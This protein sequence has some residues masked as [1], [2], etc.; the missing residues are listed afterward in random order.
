MS[1]EH[2]E[3]RVYNDGTGDALT[4]LWDTANANV[5]GKVLIRDREGHSEVDIAW[6]LSD[7]I[8][9]NELT[10]KEWSSLASLAEHV[11]EDELRDW[12]QAEEPEK[13]IAHHAA[14][15]YARLY[16]SSLGTTGQLATFFGF[17]E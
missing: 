14:R 15:L 12:V 7:T 4:V 9:P 5:V 3:W 8:K 13:H 10:P 16:Q 2:E 11:I 6:V 17:K 1:R